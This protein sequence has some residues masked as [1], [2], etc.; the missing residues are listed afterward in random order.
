MRKIVV[1]LDGSTGSTA[2]LRWAAAEARIHGAPLTALFAWDLLRQPDGFSP[3]FDETAAERAARAWI[4]EA[5]LTDDLEVHVDVVCDLPGAAIVEA[6]GDADLVVVGSRGRGGFKGLLLG[7]VSSVVAERAACPVAV[8]R[9]GERPD[10]P[11]VVGVDGSTNAH[12]ALTWAVAEAG[13]RGVPLEVVHA[14]SGASAPALGLPAVIPLSYAEETAQHTLDQVVR[15]IDGSGV[16]V[17]PQTVE[18]TPAG[19]LVGKSETAGLVVVGTRGRGGL[20]SILLGSTS[21]HL[22]HHAACTVVVVR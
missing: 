17:R 10:G 8:V 18:G 13:V 9:D 5:G 22:L 14:W 6:S 19:V 15:G 12:R 20:A 16:D 11:V 7:S 1:G 3:D 2:A 21:R 4:D